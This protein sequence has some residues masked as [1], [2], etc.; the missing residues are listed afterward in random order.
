M[1]P[2]HGREGI[3]YVCYPEGDGGSALWKVSYETGRATRVEMEEAPGADGAH[4]QVIP[5]ALRHRN[6]IH[7]GVGHITEYILRD[8][9]YDE[10]YRENGND[11][12]MRFGLYEEPHCSCMTCR[13]INRRGAE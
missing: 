8:C 10:C 7:A 2:D 9:G 11:A 12:V 3:D 5:A 6:I 4:R 1:K 13:R